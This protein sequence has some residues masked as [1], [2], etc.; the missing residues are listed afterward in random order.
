MKAILYYGTFKKIMEVHEPLRTIAIP[1]PV[2][3]HTL[4]KQPDPSIVESNVLLFDLESSPRIG[5]LLVY[6]YSGEG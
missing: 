2:V 6:R 4:D 1:K 3:I 5:E